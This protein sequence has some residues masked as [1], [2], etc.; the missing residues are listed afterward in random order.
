M[1]MYT[2]AVNYVDSCFR[3]KG[4]EL[5]AETARDTLRSELRQAFQDTRLAKLYNTNINSVPKRTHA[6]FKRRGYKYL[7][8]IFF[9]TDIWSIDFH[10]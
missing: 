1:F 9:H 5:S 2:I 4:Q 3:L 6:G 10:T 7:F 8:D